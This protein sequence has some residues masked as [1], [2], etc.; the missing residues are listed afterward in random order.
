MKLGIKKICS[1]LCCAMLSST[2]N[3]IIEFFDGK[4]YNKEQLARDFA[5]AQVK[6]DTYEYLWDLKLYSDK[7][8]IKQ[9]LQ[10]QPDS[11]FEQNE[12]F[13]YF[14]DCKLESLDDP[15]TI[16]ALWKQNKETDWE[17]ASNIILDDNWVEIDFIFVK[18]PGFFKGKIMLEELVKFLMEKFKEKN[19]ILTPKYERL[20]SFYESCNFKLLYPNSELCLRMIY[21]KNKY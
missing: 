11:F 6:L 15:S 12:N 3:A 5:L 2:T 20:I 13:S 18:K 17:G 9:I 10:Q 8:F 19:I 1:I 21:D 16:T 4:N 7:R 14:L